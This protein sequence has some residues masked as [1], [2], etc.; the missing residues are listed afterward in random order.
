MPACEEA[1]Q[2]SN[3]SGILNKQYLVQNMEKNPVTAY[4]KN[5]V[6]RQEMK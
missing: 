1:V 6:F 2:E 5:L 4:I 3:G